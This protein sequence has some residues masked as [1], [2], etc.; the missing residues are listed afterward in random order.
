[1]SEEE[2]SLDIIHEAL[3]IGSEEKAS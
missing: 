1:V 2:E 3:R